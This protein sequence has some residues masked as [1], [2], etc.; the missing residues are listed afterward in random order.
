MIEIHICEVCQNTNLKSVLNLGLHPLCDDLIKVG[1]DSVSTE[2]P[3]EI[4]HCDMCNT[5]HQRFQVPKKNLF[6]KQYHY[7]SKFTADVLSGMQNLLAECETKIGNLKDCVVVD[8]GCNDGS[9]LNFFREKGAVTVGIEP[10]DAADDAIENAHAVYKDYFTDSV[11]RDVVKAHGHP[12]IICFTNVFAHIEDL[13]SLI[14]AIDIMMDDNTILVIENHYLGAVINSKQFDTFYHEHP[15]TYSVGSFKCIAE[16]LDCVIIDASFPS[17]YGGNIR[18]FLGK[19]STFTSKSNQHLENIETNEQ[20]FLADLS[21]L[22]ISI[23]LWR[24]KKRAEIKSLVDAH[25][26]IVAKAFPGRA[27]ILMKLL[28]LDTDLIAAIYEK[29]GSLKIGH[30]A[31]GT[32]IEILSDD[33]LCL[34]THGSKPILNLAWHIPKEIKAYLRN[35]GFSGSVIDII[36]ADNFD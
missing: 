10:T 19:K 28:D 26:P 32:R 14:R 31:P 33:D 27:A 20:T 34:D 7:R 4:L 3:I 18:A 25:G 35:R 13:N 30:Y 21:K 23:G 1:N 6:P 24:D 36:S 8:V 22:E 5:C 16:T 29:P 15:R 17:R 12:K 9:L 2:Y 11:S